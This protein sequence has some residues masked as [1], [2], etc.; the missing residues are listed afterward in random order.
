MPPR[1][2]QPRSFSGQRPQNGL[3][4][5]RTPRIKQK[6]QRSPSMMGSRLGRSRR[7]HRHRF[8]PRP[9]PLSRQPSRSLPTRT[10]RCPQSSSSYGWRWV[11]RPLRS[12]RV[13]ICIPEGTAL[14]SNSSNGACYCP[15]A[16]SGGRPVRP[17]IFDR[18]KDSQ[19][20]SKHQA[21]KGI[22]A[23]RLGCRI[24]L[25]VSGSVSHFSKETEAIDHRPVTPTKNTRAQ[26]SLPPPADYSDAENSASLLI[27]RNSLL[28]RLQ[29]T[30]A[31]GTGTMT[32]SAPVSPPRRVRTMAG[33]DHPWSVCDPH[34]YVEAHRTN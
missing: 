5:R 4:G 25:P 10:A 22:M 13:N 8:R 23:R 16:D 15:P 11:S 14:T 32:P 21:A 29:Q 18:L 24:Y 1:Q 31:K 27:E 9:S 20:S 6:R 3:P 19:S 30:D 26:A 34:D 2:R 17:S 7:K 28:R 12:R 33:V